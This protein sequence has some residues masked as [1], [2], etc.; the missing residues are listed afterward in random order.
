MTPIIQVVLNLGVA[1]DRLARTA[2]LDYF[3][4]EELPIIPQRGDRLIFSLAL[5]CVGCL[6]H[7]DELLGSFW[8]NGI[9]LELHSPS[10]S[11]RSELQVVD[12][13][14]LCVWRSAIQVVRR[15]RTCPV[16][17][18]T[19]NACRKRYVVYHLLVVLINWNIKKLP[20]CSNGNRFCWLGGTYFINL[21][22]RRFHF[23]NL[24]GITSRGWCK[25][26]NRSKL[27]KSQH[28]SSAEQ[29]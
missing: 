9:R 7:D 17:Y 23:N 6:W 20:E 19:Y 27:L 21:S 11:W 16:P 12:R 29:R 1:G 18:R 15:V 28:R 3:G 10:N 5:V 14:R 26:K 8:S 13:L 2:H 24:A 25:I 22:K 4:D